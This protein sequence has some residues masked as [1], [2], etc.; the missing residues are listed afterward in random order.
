MS[1]SLGATTQGRIFKSL[2]PKGLW[3]RPLDNGTK[4][5][6]RSSLLKGK[7]GRVGLFKEIT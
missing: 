3:F 1:R 6:R 2:M 5:T 4:T 7:I